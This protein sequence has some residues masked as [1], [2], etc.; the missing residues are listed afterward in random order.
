MARYVDTSRPGL[1]YRDPSVEDAIR[2]AEGRGANGI[3]QP[4][5]PR[6]VFGP[7]GRELHPLWAAYYRGEDWRESSSS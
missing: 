5:V 2:R 7:R 3:P 6:D 4:S 1:G